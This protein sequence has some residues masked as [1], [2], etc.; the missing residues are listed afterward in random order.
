MAGHG[1]LDRLVLAVKLVANGRPDKVGTIRI[2]PLL[3]EEVDMTK[4][5]VAEID[6]N[7]L[8]VARPGSK[9]AHIVDHPY[10]FHIPSTW[11]VYSR[12][13]AEFQAAC[14]AHVR[15]MAASENPRTTKALRPHPR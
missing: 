9:L 7:L 14:L 8:T 2:E 5:N 4:V 13:L 1:L 3:H 15:E 12:R 6:G 11:M 10:T